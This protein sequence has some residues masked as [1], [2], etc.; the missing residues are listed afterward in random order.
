[1]NK[2]QLEGDFV[3]LLERTAKETGR[4]LKASAVEVATYAA[5]RAAY[6]ATISGE[7]GFEQAVK[8]E[9]DSVTLRAGIAAV[10]EA[11]AIDQRVVGI[12]HTGLLIGARALATV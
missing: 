4:S 2:N 9:R 8:A 10:A 1:M 5:D 6:L 11:D 3:E 7:P 12:I